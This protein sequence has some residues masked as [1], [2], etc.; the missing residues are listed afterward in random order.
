MLFVFPTA[1]PWFVVPLPQVPLDGVDDLNSSFFL[2]RGVSPEAAAVMRVLGFTAPL[3]MIENGLTTSATP[4]VE[5][6]PM[7]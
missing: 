4:V 2:Y 7:G 3:R 6:G 5:A 1:A